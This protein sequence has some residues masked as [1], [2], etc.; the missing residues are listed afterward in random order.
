[1]RASD[2]RGDTDAMPADPGFTE[3]RTARLAI[4]RF[5]AEDAVAFAAYRSDPNVARYQSWDDCTPEHAGAF[6]SEMAASHPGVPGE[7]FQF[8][9]GDP[10]SD[11]LLGD[12]A[13]CVHA[14]DTS[15][16]ELGF[17]FAPAH[18]G[19]GYATEAA[20]AVIAYA[21]ERL[22]A[23][24]VLGIADARND[25]SIALLERIGMRR[26]ATEHVRFKDEWCDEHTYELRRDEG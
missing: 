2:D 6:V 13:I 7:W 21:F 15:R 25:A 17:T 23:E 1:V 24:T 3:L 22:G 11:E 18:Q 4:R 14:D 26:A 9:V 16:A 19:K 12:V 8:A 20:R 5:R 10:A